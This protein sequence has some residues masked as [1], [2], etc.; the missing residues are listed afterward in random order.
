MYASMKK[1]ILKH[2]YMAAEEAREKLDVF[3]AKNRLDAGQY[4]ELTDLVNTVY[5][6][7]Y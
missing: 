5:H 1:L 4:E 6:D 3:F 7:E 2:F